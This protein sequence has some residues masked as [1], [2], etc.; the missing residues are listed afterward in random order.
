MAYLGETYDTDALPVSDRPDNFEPLP[1][2]WY[3]VQIISAELK[4]TKA[5]NGQYI[6]LRYDVTGPTHAGR[7]IWGKLN[8][9]NASPDAERI[10]RQQFGE[11]LRAI[12]L[13]RVE[14][15]DQLIGHALSIRV[16]TTPAKG[17]YEAKSEPKAYRALGSAPA[18][19]PN[20][21]RG[22]FPPPPTQA[23]ASASTQSA[24]APAAASSGAPPWAK[25]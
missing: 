16:A 8:I 20:P 9:R 25:K 13:P 7:V 22:M 11:L 5:G 18:S 23:A 19:A 2:G 24:P 12:G 3:D 14:D 15:T 21:Q 17:D 1:P 4:M 10:G 6:N